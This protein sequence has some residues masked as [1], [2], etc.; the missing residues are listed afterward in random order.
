MK[1]LFFS[2]SF[3]PAYNGVISSLIN[4]ANGLCELGHEVVIV[5]SG[6]GE[7][8]KI[9][10]LDK[11]VKVINVPSVEVKIYPDA[12]LGLPSYRVYRLLKSFD[13][14]VVVINYPAVVG[15]MGVFFAKK[16]KIP[17]VFV[18][19]TTFLNKEI[20][21]FFRPLVRNVFERIHSN[22]ESAVAWFIKKSNVVLAPSEEMVREVKSFGI[23]TRVQLV[24]LS[25]P[26][27]K[28]M[29]V[30]AK[31]E[32]LRKKMIKDRS[33]IYVGRLSAE[34]NVNKVIELFCKLRDDLPELKLVLVGDGPERKSLEK[35]AESMGCFGDI[36]WVGKVE[37][38][39]LI[40]NGY[41][42]LGDVFVTLSTVDALGLS[43]V[44]AMACG[45]PV[46]GVR[47]SVT[48]E[49]AGKA[50]IYIDLELGQKDIEEVKSLFVDKN[51]YRRLSKIALGEVD[52]FRESYCASLLVD[53]C[54]GRA[55]E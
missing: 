35:K 54:E 2:D 21:L 20:K 23:D 17:I 42:Y 34:K 41:F 24:P 26:V 9:L 40:S 29:D 45:L 31:G 33:L 27:N 49:V 11:R 47:G 55:R 32:K 43:T 52:R 46:I 28:L 18:Y 7:G 36:L 22:V 51:K 50:G 4:M 5:C 1:Y 38:A 25:A 53:S 16:E 6:E 39:K 14:D 37:Y 10:L 3:L 8:K 15:C 13:A 30:K 44:E 19:N 12:R 48:E